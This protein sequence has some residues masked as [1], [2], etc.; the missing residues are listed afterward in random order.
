MLYSSTIF[1]RNQNSM[2]NLL[3]IIVNQFSTFS[4]NILCIDHVCSYVMRTIIWWSFHYSSYDS[5]AFF[6]QMRWR[7]GIQNA[8]VPFIM[9]DRSLLQ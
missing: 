2:D 8:P 7:D 9:D 1:T 6:M 3:L 4:L 5:K